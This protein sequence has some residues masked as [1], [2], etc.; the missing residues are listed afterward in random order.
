MTRRCGAEADEA[1]VAVKRK[2]SEQREGADR[3]VIHACLER[4]LAERQTFRDD[5]ASIVAAIEEAWDKIASGHD[6]S[7]MLLECVREL[8]NLL[9]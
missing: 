4:D 6:W 1:I 9:R 5:L 2:I 7:E 8:D 3:R